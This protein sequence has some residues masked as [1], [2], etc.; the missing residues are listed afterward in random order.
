MKILIIGKVLTNPVT[1]GN[2]RL[3][4]D[5]TALLRKMGHEVHYLFVQERSIHVSGKEEQTRINGLKSF[6]KDDLHVFR[7]SF[8]LDGGDIVCQPYAI[9]C[10]RLCQ[11]LRIIQRYMGSGCWGPDQCRNVDRH[12]SDPRPSIV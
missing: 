3:I 7:L 5:Q 1:M 9:D 4:V 6:W 2:Q 10:R 11:C 8:G 12:V